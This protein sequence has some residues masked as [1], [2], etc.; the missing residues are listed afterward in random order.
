MRVNTPSDYHRTWPL[1]AGRWISLILLFALS[2]Q[3]VLN[4]ATDMPIFWSDLFI[5][6]DPETLM[7][8]QGEDDVTIMVTGDV[9]L[10]RTVNACMVNEEDWTFPLATVAPF[11]SQADVTWVNLETPIV[12]ECPLRYQGRR[13]C[14]D[15]RT[16]A[17]LTLA[18]VD[19]ANIANNHAE[20]QGAE[21]VAETV[22][23]L[24]A[25]DI[26]VTGRAKAVVLEVKGKTIGMLGFNEVNPLKS[27]TQALPA[28]I[29]AQ[30]RSL[31]SK[32]DYVLV[33]FHWGIEYRLTQNST[34]RNLAKIAIDAGADAVIG[35]HPHW[36]QGVEVY[37]GKPIVYSLGNF[38]FDMGEGGWVNDG[39]IALVTLKADGRLDLDL[40]PVVIENS[41]TPRLA[42]EKEANSILE[43][44]GSVSAILPEE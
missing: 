6:Q 20:D 36:V 1:R 33:V 40:V 3:T 35:H 41:S 24:E 13:F 26:D 23:F 28:T 27:V 42:T 38:V 21:G 43:R 32:V 9:L 7:A 4:Q 44:M 22:S 29:E 34:Q 37:Q 5:Y 25:I 18:G 19:V 31:R 10:A 15:P 14:G 30:V 39:A 16:L 17:S 8:S 11:L 12:S 2:V